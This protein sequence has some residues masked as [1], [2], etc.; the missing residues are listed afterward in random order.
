[1]NTKT[2]IFSIG[3]GLLTSCN[4]D[5][6]KVEELEKK[7]EQQNSEMQTMKETMMEKELEQKDKEIEELK[8]QQVNSIQP[9]EG[10][11][12]TKF[13]AKGFGQYPE[14]SNRLLTNSDVAHLPNGELTI[15]RNEIFARHGYIFKTQEMIKHFSK[16]NWYRPLYEEV[17]GDLSDIEKKNV[18]FIK[19][20]E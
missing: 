5:N 8:S 17:F 19:S 20:F 7:L 16:Q 14:A 11:Q 10:E 3:L 18:Q 13:Y 1:M 2:I 6:A 12:S 15:M 4:N 9:N